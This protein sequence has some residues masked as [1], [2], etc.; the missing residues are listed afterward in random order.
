MRWGAAEPR[1]INRE[2]SW[3]AFNERVLEEAL[4]P[5]VPL[6]ERLKFSAITASNLEEFCMVRVAGL[7]GQVIDGSDKRSQDG[8]SAQEQLALIGPQAAS[9]LRR[10]HDHFHDVIRVELA[11]AGVE[12]VQGDDLTEAERVFVAEYFERETFPLLTPLAIDPGHPFPNVRNQCLTLLCQL[13]GAGGNLPESRVILEQHAL[14]ARGLARSAPAGVGQTPSA[15]H[16]EGRT[17]RP[18]TFGVVTVPTILPRV[19]ALPRTVDTKSARFIPLEAVIALHIKRLF[20]G[21]ECLGTW[22]F[23]VLRNFDLSIDEE[24][25]DDL[26]E[27]I[28]EEV[29][30][31]HHEHAVCLIHDRTLTGEGLALLCEALSLEPEL[32]FGV[33]RPLDL[34]G[35]SALAQPLKDQPAH[36]ERPFKPQRLGVFREAHSVFEAIAR[37]DILL[38]HPYESFDPVVEFIE[39]AAADPDVLAIKQT[40]YRTS[41]DSP[42]VKALIR[43]AQARKQVTALVEIKARFDEENNII[44][45]Q[46]L[47]EAGVHVVYGLVGLKTHCKIALVVRRERGRLVRYVHLGTGNY[48]PS[49]ARIYT[50][51]S[52]FTASEVFGEDATQL[53]NMLTSCT[54]PSE[55]QRFVVAPIDLHDRILA[56]IQRETRHAQAGNG[57]R[58]IAKMNSLVDPEVI[59]A[60]YAASDAGVEIDLIVRG[61]CCLRGSVPGLSENIRVISIVDRFLEHARVFYFANQGDSDVFISSADW[62]QRNF[63]RRVEVMFPIEDE[64]IKRQLVDDMLA[65]QLADNVKTRIQGADGTYTRR[66]PAKGEAPLRCQATLIE[67]AEAQARAADAQAR[68]ERPFLVRPTRTRPHL[69]LPLGEP[70]GPAAER[71]PSPADAHPELP[72]VDAPP[73]GTPLP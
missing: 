64:A 30:R 3:L 44:W 35:L 12:L 46:A 22:P 41:G 53:F 11:Q 25:A 63:H 52:L 40:L 13:T 14:I 23:R 55:W 26:L 1:L 29:L 48:N 54:V 59:E 71:G 72:P 70:H 34:P 58:I 33:R 7:R 28:R 42:I 24:E 68:Q 57:G 20:P 27:S 31:R 67:A 56:L 43:A 73:E 32:A 49:T 62:M 16:G 60:L 17:G 21:F 5:G 65:V 15:E 45:A 6:V 38:H 39:E 69:G 8:L 51:I 2:L 9:M 4:D 19:V 36:H 47:E 18:A 37:G 50:D 66:R 10:L 61:I